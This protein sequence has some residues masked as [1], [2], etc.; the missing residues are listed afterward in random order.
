MEEFFCT[1]T[2]TYYLQDCEQICWSWFHM[3]WKW[4]LI[5]NLTDILVLLSRL[6]KLARVKC[7]S[8][9]HLFETVI[10]A[11]VRTVWV[12]GNALS[13]LQLAFEQ[14]QNHEHIDFSFTPSA[15][16]VFQSWF[17]IILFTFKCLNDLAPPSLTWST[18][19]IYHFLTRFI[20]LDL[21]KWS[22]LSCFEGFIQINVEDYCI[23][24]K[25]IISFVL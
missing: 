8:S 19:Q 18:L 17:Q 25:Y 3:V 11:F 13:Q 5:L 20:V 16:S 12:K 23:C 2:S 10:H 9:Q 22:D 21:L 7:I 14:G 6:V 15:A 4:T 1:V 24:A